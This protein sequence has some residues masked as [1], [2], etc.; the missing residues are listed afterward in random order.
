MLR[1]FGVFLIGS[2]TMASSP[3]SVIVSW[4]TKVMNSCFL[5]LEE[6]PSGMVIE[7]PLRVMALTFRLRLFTGPWAV[8]M[9]LAIAV[10]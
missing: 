3:S 10:P 5:T 9:P 7:V 8:T 2:T 1:L 6:P 4:L